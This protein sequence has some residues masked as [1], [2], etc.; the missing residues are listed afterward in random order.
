MKA[1]LFGDVSPTVITE[2]LFV[3]KDVETLFTDVVTLFEGNDIN[4]VNLECAVTDYEKDIEKFEL[5][6]SKKENLNLC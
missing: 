5:Q 4:F 6:I 1:L 2:P 3:Q